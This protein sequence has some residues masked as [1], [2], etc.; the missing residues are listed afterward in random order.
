[1][2]DPGDIEQQIPVATREKQIKRVRNKKSDMC[3]VFIFV[4]SILLL[5]VF[6]FVYSMTT[7]QIIANTT[8][9]SSCVPYSEYLKQRGITYFMI[10]LFCGCALSFIV[11]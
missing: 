3:C 4:N 9:A 7:Q 6:G 5:S 10:I 11:K 1:M 2:L 8:E